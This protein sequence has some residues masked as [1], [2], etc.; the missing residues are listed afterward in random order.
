MNVGFLSP[1]ER[2]FSEAIDFYNEQS[3]GLGYLLAAEVK[4]A[5]DRIIQYP[6]AWTS[7][8]K[9]TRRCIVNK[10]PYALIYQLRDNLILIVAV[11][12][13]HRHPDSWQSRLKDKKS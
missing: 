1:A 6:E 3:E 4:K 9:R 10:F 13:L 11:Q 5:I 7:L 12:N 8:S 2:E